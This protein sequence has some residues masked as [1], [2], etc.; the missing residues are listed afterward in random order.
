MSEFK[1]KTFHEQFKEAE[2]HTTVKEAMAKHGLAQTA[3]DHLIRGGTPP[4]KK[5][6]DNPGVPLVDLMG[7]QEIE[8]AIEQYYRICDQFPNYTREILE[9]GI[10]S[11]IQRDKSVKSPLTKMVLYLSDVG[12]LPDKY[13]HLVEEPK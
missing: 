1:E 6:W 8:G 3:Y 10:I 9:E 2:K 11:E 12:K 7:T 4:N 5:M 13:K